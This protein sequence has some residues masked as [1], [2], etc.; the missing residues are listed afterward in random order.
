MPST[1]RT[2]K[3]NSTVKQIMFDLSGSY[4]L[5]TLSLQDEHHLE[6]RSLAT[7]SIVTIPTPYPSFWTTLANQ[8]ALAVGFNAKQVTIFAWADPLQLIGLI[9]KD[10]GGD[11][12]QV[13]GSIAV[14]NPRRPSKMWPLSPSEVDSTVHKV[15]SSPD[16]TLILVE[17]FGN[18][19]Q[20]RRRSNCLLIESKS[21]VYNR[22]QGTVPVCSIPSPL[23]DVLCV[24]LGFVHAESLVPPRCGRGTTPW[25]RGPQRTFAFIN[26]D[27]WVC[28][29]DVVF[30]M[31]RTPQVRKHFFLPMDW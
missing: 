18:T 9:Y 31:S 17:I 25:N 26:K 19:R 12:D 21:L 29:V 27:F 10:L 16:D 24:S 23:L 6:I 28:S 22:A 8:D 4:L 13:Q 1:L 30:G 14:H 3:E 5:V 11:S 15:L 20:A 2:F 7:P